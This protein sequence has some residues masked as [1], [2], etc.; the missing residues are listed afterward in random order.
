MIS[1]SIVPALT[2]ALAVFTWT[3]NTVPRSDA[4]LAAIIERHR[5]LDLADNLA[6][7]L[8]ISHFEDC[9]FRDAIQFWIA[10][11]ADLRRLVRHPAGEEAAGMCSVGPVCRLHR[12]TGRAAGKKPLRK[13]TRI[14]FIKIELGD[15]PLPDLVIFGLR[16]VYGD[17]LI[18]RYN[19]SLGPVAAL[20]PIDRVWRT[21]TLPS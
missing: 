12:K 9:P 16:R 19:L 6:F 14:G 18:K 3:A 8:L 10:Q 15:Q 2:T 11:S 5:D 7:I 17:L 1:A 4:C 13:V 21:N 20:A